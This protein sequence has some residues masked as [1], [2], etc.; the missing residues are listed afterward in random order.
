MPIDTIS[1]GGTTIKRAWRRGHLVVGSNSPVFAHVLGALAVPLDG[2]APRGSL[3]AREGYRA[4]V[5]ELTQPGESL[6]AFGFLNAE[7]LLSKVILKAAT[8][9]REKLEKLGLTDV[10]GVGIG[11]GLGPSGGFVDRIV[12]DAPQAHRGLFMALRALGRLDAVPV[13]RRTPGDAFLAAAIDLSPSALY[14][15]VQHLVRTTGGP[16]AIER[17]DQALDGFEREFGFGL[18]EVLKDVSGQAT[19][20]ASMPDGGEGLYPEI[21]AR[22]RLKDAERARAHLDAI[23]ARLTQ[24]G[25]DRPALDVRTIPSPDGSTFRYVN[26]ASLGGVS[27]I[28]PAFA[29]VGEDLLVALTPMHLKRVL[30]RERGYAA[31]TAVGQGVTVTDGNLSGSAEAGPIA[32]RAAPSLASSPAWTPVADEVGKDT[33]AFAYLDAPKILRGLY[34]TYGPFFQAASDKGELPFEPA[35][36]PTATTVSKHLRSATLTFARRPTGYAITLRGPLSPFVFLGTAATI[37]AF[38]KLSRKEAERRLLA[39]EPDLAAVAARAM[40]TVDYSFDRMDLARGLEELASR[41]GV[42]I[43]FPRESMESVQI[44][45]RGEQVQLDRAVAALLEGTSYRARARSVPGGGM[46]IVV[47]EVPDTAEGTSGAEDNR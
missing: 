31:E 7:E 18:Y 32:P 9:E 11:T 23:L 43:F 42:S 25:A 10:R 26:L 37:D 35:L 8:K 40:P 4:V 6:A 41:S 13:L 28:E 39:G 15:V 17:F 1:K 22:F 5:R 16:E 19:L 38:G 44:T 27:P 29:I 36:L 3:A 47:Y 30:E 24:A 12:V 33:H 2:V 34:N 20:Y 46:Q 14:H 21:T 45:A